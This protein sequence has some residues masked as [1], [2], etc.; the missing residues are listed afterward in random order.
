MHPDLIALPAHLG[1]IHQF[2]HSDLGMSQ[3]AG[4]VLI[5]LILAAIAVLGVIGIGRRVFG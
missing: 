1:P 5:M 2:L 3:H 4:T